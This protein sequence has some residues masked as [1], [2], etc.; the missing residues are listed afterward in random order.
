MHM[1]GAM[2]NDQNP[3]NPLRDT[4]R[5]IPSIDGNADETRVT[6]PVTET[7]HIPLIGNAAP[8][9]TAGNHPPR[10]ARRVQQPLPEQMKPVREGGKRGRRALIVLSVIL[11][12]ALIAYIGGVVAFSN[13][14]YPNTYIA[15][16]DVSLM[17]AKTAAGRVES[18]ATNYKL[19]VTGGD[20]SWEYKPEDPTTLIDG[21]ARAKGILEQNEPMAWPYRLYQALTAEKPEHDID[22]DAALPEEF[23]A[24][25]LEEQISAAVAAHNEGRSGT[26]DSASAFDTEKGA[27]TLERARAN[28]IL[29]AAKVTEDIEFAL[30]NLVTKLELGDDCFAPLAGGA[31][32]EEVRAACDAANKLVGR[33]ITLTMGGGTAATFDA[34]KLSQWVSFD[35]K[36]AP[37]LDTGAATA[38]LSSIA[39]E[40]LNTVGSERSY[41]RPDGK[42]VTVSGDTWGWEIESGKL[43]EQIKAALEAEGDATIEVPT[44]KSGDRFTA[45]GERDWNAYIDVDLTEQYARF[46]DKDDQIIWEAHVITGNPN[47]GDDTPTGIY[48]MNQP[49]KKIVLRGPL[50]DK[51]AKKY[52]WES[53]VDYWMPFVGSSIGFHDATWQNESSF[54]DPTAY[55]WCGSRGCVNLTLKKAGELYSLVYPGLCVVVHW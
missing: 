52:E 35:E 40:Q 9:S 25:A 14:F 43:S 21:A 3:V 36:L 4:G 1:D 20:F 30:A 27:Y 23:D 34:A 53:P 24:A 6:P 33:T 22:E 29:D 54:S 15:D 41:T 48:H 39:K 12:L 51:E 2:T 47:K 38:D 45:H 50:I 13:I 11:G 8:G 32:D 26:F 16:V 10:P 7:Q 44:K 37:A 55:T 19:T 5:G 49:L 46:Y 31:T 18:S 28:A 17:D 42:N